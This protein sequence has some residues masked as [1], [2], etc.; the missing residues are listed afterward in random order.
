MTIEH[1]LMLGFILCDLGENLAR[2]RTD[3]KPG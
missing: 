2:K 1:L 3:F